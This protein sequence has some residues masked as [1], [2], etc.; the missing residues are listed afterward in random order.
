MALFPRCLIEAFLMWIFYCGCHLQFPRARIGC[1]HLKNQYFGEN[2]SFEEDWR[3]LSSQQIASFKNRQETSQW[4]GCPTW[5]F[6]GG[7]M[8][9]PSCWEFGLK[10]R[11]PGSLLEMARSDTEGLLCVRHC[12]KHFVH[13]YRHTITP[14]SGYSHTWGNWG[15]QKLALAGTALP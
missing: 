5:Q 8:E 15:P 2:R 10:A 1:I 14:P 3:T 13:M 12:A 9:C 4:C 7:P 6:S 11:G